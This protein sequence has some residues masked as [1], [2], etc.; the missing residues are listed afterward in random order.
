MRVFI[1]SYLG[2]ITGVY[3]CAVDGAQAVRALQRAGC[4]GAVV[5]EA[6][7]NSE[8]ETGSLLMAGGV[9]AATSDV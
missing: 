7:L 5:C 1:V 4:C 2:S 3:S 6:R 9:I 8:T